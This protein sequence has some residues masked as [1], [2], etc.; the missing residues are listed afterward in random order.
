FVFNF[1]GVGQAKVADFHPATDALQF[2]SPIFATAQAALNA[3]Q[4]DGHGNTVVT[5]DAHDTITLAGV[6]KAQLNVGDFHVV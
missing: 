6:L 2:S 4:D 1:V 3:T 5:L